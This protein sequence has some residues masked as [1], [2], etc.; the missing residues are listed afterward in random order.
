M[1]VSVKVV[2][3]ED[4]VDREFFLR[5]PSTPWK[6]SPSDYPWN[7]PYVAGYLI[8]GLSEDVGWEGWECS[9]DGVTWI[10]PRRG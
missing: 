1:S 5:G 3:S 2:V 6:G 10:L 9:S 7:Y 8:E 4:G